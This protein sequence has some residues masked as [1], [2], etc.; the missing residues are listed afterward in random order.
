[1][2]QYLMKYKGTYR[3]LAELDLETNDIYR[4]REGNVDEDVELYIA[5]QYGNQIKVWGHDASGRILLEAYIPSL[6]RGRN[7]KK[8]MDEQGIFYSHYDEYTDE[9]VFRFK[10]KD[11]TEVAT[12]LKAKTS[13]ANISP[14]STKNLPKANVE[15]P[16]EKIEEYKAIIADVQKPDLLII[17]KITQAFLINILNKKYRKSDKSFRYIEDMRKM[18]MGRMAKEYIWSKNMF[19]EY[20]IYLRKEI[21]KFYKNK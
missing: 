11:I 5:C 16:L 13:G 2:S 8:A 9:V 3:I 20:L 1:M 6:G 10:A 15:I 7:I 14:F 19:D 21:N 4:D 18:K 12:L 17:H